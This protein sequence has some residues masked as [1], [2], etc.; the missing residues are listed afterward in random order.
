MNKA[1]L[2]TLVSTLTLTIAV[3]QKPNIIL[4]MADDMGFSDLG[5]FGSEIP[6]PNLDKLAQKGVRFSQ[7]YNTARCCPTR[8]SLLTGLYQHQTGI[9]MMSEDPSSNSSGKDINDAG[10]A[11][12]HGFLN[13]QCVTIA[14]VL[15]PSGYHTYMA[16]KWHVGMHGEE[17]WPLQ[18][19]FEHYY[20][21]LAGACSYLKPEGGRGLTIDNTHL[22]APQGEY[23]TTDAFTDNAI[24]M[25]KEQKDSNPFFLYLAF[26][27]PH[28][29][30]QAKKA[31]YEKFVGKYLKG[32]DVIREER[33]QRQKA[34]KLFDRDIPLSPRDK[35]VRT[36]KEVNE[37]QKKESDF[38]MAVYAAQVNCID[39]NIG[40][41]I[42]TLSDLKILDNTLIIFLSDN[43]ACAEPYQEFG[44]G[45]FE[46]I[47]NPAVSG[48]VSY[49][50]GWANVSN[51]P[52]FEYKV[53]SYEG[54]ISAPFIASWPG[55]IKKTAGTVYHT[56]ACLTDIMPT[57]IE[58]AGTKYPQSHPDGTKLF[59]IEG[60]SLL[61]AFI[62]GKGSEHKYM[63]WE[64]SGYSAIRK[65]D[66]KAY[67]KVADS[68]WELYDLRTDRDEQINVAK[69]HPEL[70]KEL[71][72][73][74]YEWANSHQVLPKK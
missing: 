31:D 14:E 46:D 70:V 73:K 71:N 58:A 60:T 33:Y 64:H 49:G 3:A 17:K 16:G 24:R 36:W 40:K 22:P 21:I 68:V 69:D 43:G 66:W 20:G 54:G 63:Y 57:F 11:G 74:W 27:A 13:H 12:Y 55:K 61:S 10:V 67:K 56:P 48:A 45:K 7:F 34:M 2:L 37:A 30:L 41:L 62:E 47:N 5:C 53:K 38:R 4:I 35:R 23:Y 32:W 65:G 25:I 51:T 19:G 42:S 18:R 39:Q 8:A 15:K 44:G 1:P 50:I 59:P 52:F 6:T 26:N 72:D 29:P 9:G 28:W